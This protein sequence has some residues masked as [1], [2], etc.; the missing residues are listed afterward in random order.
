MRRSFPPAI[1]L[2]LLI[3]LCQDPGQAAM[4]RVQVL[5]V[6][7]GDTI[8]VSMPGGKQETVRYIGIDTPETH[9]PDRGV[10]ELGKEASKANNELVFGRHVFLETDVEKRDRY[11]RMLAYVWIEKEGK[12]Y[13][14]NEILLRMGYAMPFTFPPNL[15]HTDIFREAF[16]RARRE[17]RGLWARAS[18]RRF[19]PYQLWTFL[20]SLS[21]LFVTVEMVVKRVEE[22]ERRFTLLPSGGKTTLVIYKS[23][24]P[25]FGPIGNYSGKRLTVVGKIVP[26]YAGPEIV[27]A[28]PVQILD[29]K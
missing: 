8:R 10:E 11:G 16:A 25:L 28:D 23:D 18:E 7:D 1:F 22:S 17:N 19:S 24:S 4:L 12:I 15:K 27:I 29:V 2:L 21:G 26:G 14:V 5:E 9:H 3:L 6:F 13:M 20:P